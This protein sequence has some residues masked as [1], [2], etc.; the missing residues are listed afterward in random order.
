L[1]STHT[2]THSYT[3]AEAGILKANSKW[4]MAKWRIGEM[5]NEMAII[6]GTSM[7]E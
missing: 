5:R 1:Q 4:K 7:S 2:H 6:Q 3:L